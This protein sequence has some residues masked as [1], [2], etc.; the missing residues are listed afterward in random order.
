MKIV[1]SERISNHCAPCIMHVS[2]IDRWI[3]LADAD[4]VFICPSLWFIVAKWFFNNRWIW[5]KP[6]DRKVS[7]LI[8]S[9]PNYLLINFFSLQIRKFSHNFDSSLSSR[10]YLFMLF[11]SWARESKMSSFNLEF[12]FNSIRYICL[13]FFCLATFGFLWHKFCFKKIHWSD[14]PLLQV[15]SSN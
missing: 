11:Y 15:K 9:L 4:S 8:L 14:N 6:K 1:S 7:K 5:Q 10:W 13:L 3:F 12:S 2:C